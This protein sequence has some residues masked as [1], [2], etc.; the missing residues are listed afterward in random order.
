MKSKGAEIWAVGGGKGGIGKSFIV[1]S[2]GCRLALSGRRVIVVDADLG[3]ANLHTF[4]G[5]ARPKAS[6]SD[7]FDRKCP[8]AEL[9]I[10]T[11][12]ANLGLVAGALGS[13]APDSIT[14]AQKTKF[15]R[16]LR[17]LEADHVL[18]DLGG[19][20]HYSTVDTFLQ[21]D[22][23]IVLMVAELTAI[24]NLYTFLKTVFFRNLMHVLTRNGHKDVFQDTWQHRDRYGIETL[25]AFTEHLTQASPSAG[26][27]IA[28]EFKRFKIRIVLNQIRKSSE[29]AVGRAAKSVCRKHFGLNA[30]F[31]GYLSQDDA[32]PGCVNRRQIY[33]QAFPEA[34]CV[35][36][37]ET[38]TDHLL[39]DS[40]V[41]L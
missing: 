13:L 11:G 10:D 5:M 38:L 22:K 27:L 16:Q 18:V 4:L 34:R 9:V 21:A 30:A 28:D 15:L 17:G 26:V 20:A 14:Y 8:L 25:R 2:L 24:E 39:R 23:M 1:S 37:L 29:I 32:V 36:E 41:R 40:E 7:F 19:G 3:G 35:R 33:L 12:V 6:L 31:S